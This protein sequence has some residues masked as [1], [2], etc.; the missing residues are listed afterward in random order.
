LENFSASWAPFAGGDLQIALAYYEL[1]QSDTSDTI[2]Q[3][4]SVSVTWR[5]NYWMSLTAG[6]VVSKT[7]STVQTSESRSTGADLRMQF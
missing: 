2:D 1:L 3:N 5:I 6:Y 7:G 4:R